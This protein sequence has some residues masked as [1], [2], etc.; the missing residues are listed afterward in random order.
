MDGTTIDGM[1]GGVVVTRI[2]VR[3]APPASV[4]GG[5]ASRT[6]FAVGK[7]TWTTREIRVVEARPRRQRLAA[8]PS[9]GTVH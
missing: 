3:M 5:A 8:A 1:G 4:R 9:S 2:S 7:L 6:I